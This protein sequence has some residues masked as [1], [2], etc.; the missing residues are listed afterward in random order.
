M[1]TSSTLSIA[2]DFSIPQY[3]YQIMNV[4]TVLLTSLLGLG[5]GLI[6]AGSLLANTIYYFHGRWTGHLQITLLSKR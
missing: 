4:Q 1:P 3:F 6:T 5:G 2:F